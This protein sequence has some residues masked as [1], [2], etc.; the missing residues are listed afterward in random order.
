MQFEN[1]AAQMELGRLKFEKARVER[2][3]NKV[4]KE[5]QSAASSQTD[6]KKLTA[7]TKTP[8][9]PGLVNGKNNFG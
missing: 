8:G 3:N 1:L 6:Q 5:V 2:V 9:L 4:R 7:V